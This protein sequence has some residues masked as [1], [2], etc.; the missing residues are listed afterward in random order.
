MKNLMLVVASLCLISSAGGATPKTKKED[1]SFKLG[2]EWKMGYSASTTKYTILEFI[3]GGDDIDNWK[4]L[5]TMQNFAKA[6]DKSSPEEMLNVL[7]AKREKEC[8]GA[9]EWL[10]IE[11]NESSILFEWQAKP[12]L[13]WPEQHEIARIIFGKYNVMFLHYT[14]K[15]HELA[16]GTRTEWIK[17]LAKATVV[18]RD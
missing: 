9:T 7:K 12:C 3:R 8:P 14:A 13:G 17:I 16:P 5:V 11:K 10:V 18:I 2:A 4:E 1:L 15:V 6:S